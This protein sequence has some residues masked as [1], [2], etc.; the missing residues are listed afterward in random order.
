M[1]SMTKSNK[2]ILKEWVEIGEEL[3]KDGQIIE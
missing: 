2:R 3:A 1:E